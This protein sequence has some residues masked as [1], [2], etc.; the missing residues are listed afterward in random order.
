M[1]VLALLAGV[2]VSGTVVH[3]EMTRMTAGDLE[4]MI[5]AELHS[6]SSTDQ[7]VRFLDSH[8]IEHGAVVPVEVGDPRLKDASVPEGATMVSG[9]IRNDG[10]ALEHTDVRFT[11][12][13]EADGTLEDWVVW[14]V[15]R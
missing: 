7:V 9:I 3:Y 14:E 6:E 11:L 12:I 1:V 4:G 5:E 2:V 8:D 13:M 10:D 15:K